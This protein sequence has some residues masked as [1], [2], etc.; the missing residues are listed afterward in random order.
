MGGADDQVATGHEVVVADQI[1]RRA[2]LGQVLVGLAGDA[3][4]V[5]PALL[6]LAEGLGGAGDSLVDDDGLDVGVIGQTGDLLDGG[7]HLVGEVV[8]IGSQD[9]AVLT[10]HGL[11]GLG[12]AAVV[13]RLRDGAGDNA[14][15]VGIAGGIGAG[16]SGLSA[17]GSLRAASAAGCEGQQH[18]SCQHGADYSFH[19]NL[20]I[21]IS[22]AKGSY[23]FYQAFIFCQY[24][25]RKDQT[26]MGVPNCKTGVENNK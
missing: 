26:S 7:L 21:F 10:I 6:D 8:R 14:D 3:E 5:R 18:D 12:A 20:P 13:L 23:L 25:S 2:D 16:F 15:L 4:D 19:T 9:N 24:F 11:E 17:G 22:S 1:S